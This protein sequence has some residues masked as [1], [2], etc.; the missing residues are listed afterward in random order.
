MKT[1]PRVLLAAL[2]FAAVVPA[3]SFADEKIPASGYFTATV[4]FSTLSLAPVGDNCLLEVEGV[5]EFTG[6]LDGIAPAR[7]RALVLASCEHV[8]FNPPGAFKDIFKSRLEFAGTVNGV[9]TVADMTYQGITE[10]GGKMEAVF[11]FSDGLKGVLRV[12]AIVAVGGS[13]RG[14]LKPSWAD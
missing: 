10:V 4:D 11:T 12:D 2:L 6:T 3:S 1:S 13:Y 9:P 14:F 8:A 5:I 7:T